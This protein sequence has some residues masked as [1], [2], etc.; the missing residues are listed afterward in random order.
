MKKKIVFSLIGGIIVFVLA[1]PA[2]AASSDYLVSAQE[3]YQKYCQR[4][5][6]PL[7]QALGC[8][9]F[10]KVQELQ[11]QISEVISDNDNQSDE[12][13]QLNTLVSDLQTSDGNFESR[14]EELENSNN[15]SGFPTPDFDS[16]WIELPPKNNVITVP[17]NLEGNVN[18][19]FVDVQWL[20]PTGLMM[21]HQTASNN[22]WWEDLNSEDIQIVTNGDQSN[23]F[24][25]ARVRIWKSS[26]LDGSPYYRAR[27]PVN[28]EIRT[29]KV[30]EPGTYRIVA[31]NTYQWGNNANTTIADPEWM[32]FPIEF[33]GWKESWDTEGF[34]LE[35]DN[36]DLQVD[37]QFV[38]WAGKQADGTY[39]EHEYSPEHKYQTIKDITNEVS[40]RLYDTDYH[41]NV[42]EIEVVLYKVD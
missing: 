31:E 29:I 42:G 22:V 39:Q 37:N 12:I 33:T 38:N 25:A 18:D 28:G 11:T 14:L 2:L 35:N 3:A 6:T 9:A 20:R 15:T 7:N 21:S 23:L 5:K 30:P 10:E 19:Y 8:Y 16:G 17:H 27:I 13:N 26:P 24:I 4:A 41:D 36:L 34:D 40:F 1:A 32:Y